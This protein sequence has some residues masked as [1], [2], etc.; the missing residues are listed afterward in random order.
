VDIQKTIRLLYEGP[1]AD[2][3]DYY[4]TTRQDIE[5]HLV[6]SAE[7]EGTWLHDYFHFYTSRMD[8]PV[9]LLEGHLS[10]T[11]PNYGQYKQQIPPVRG[12]SESRDQ[13]GYHIYEKHDWAHMEV[14]LVEP[15]RNPFLADLSAWMF[16]WSQG[17]V[18]IPVLDSRNK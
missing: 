17:E 15:D 13:V 10:S 12:Q 11:Y 9:Y 14:L 4:F 18:Q 1:G 7:T 3:I 2:Y 6:G 16:Y 5:D 8:A